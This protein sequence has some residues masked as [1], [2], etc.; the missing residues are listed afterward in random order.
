MGERVFSIL[1]SSPKIFYMKK[2]LSIKHR[3]LYEENDNVTPAKYFSEKRDLV[4]VPRRQTEEAEMKENQMMK[5]VGY[6]Y[7]P[8]SGRIDVW[9]KRP[10]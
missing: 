3:G 1:L 5:R 9:I 4:F 7:S 10:F 6:T 8:L 2:A